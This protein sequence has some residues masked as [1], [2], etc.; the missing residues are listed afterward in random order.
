MHWRVPW[1]AVG[2]AGR[3]GDA[4]PTGS[5]ERTRPAPFAARAARGRSRRGLGSVLEL[6]HVGACFVEQEDL[7]SDVGF[8]IRLAEKHPD[9][10]T[11]RLFD[12]CGELVGHLLL[13]TAADLLDRVDFATCDE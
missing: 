3:G 11:G 8:E 9:L 5:V 10:A 12:Q 4:K 13:E 1:K 6:G 2:R 7:D